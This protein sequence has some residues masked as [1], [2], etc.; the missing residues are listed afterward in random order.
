M[1]GDCESAFLEGGWTGELTTADDSI[2]YDKFFPNRLN[3]FNFLNDLLNRFRMQPESDKIPSQGKANIKTVAAAAGVS[4]ATVSNAFNR[5][6]QLSAEVRERVLNVAR[7]IGYGGANPVA[8]N[9]RR[10]STN[11]VGFVY[12]ESLEFGLNDPASQQFLQGIAR[13]L[14]S[15]GL[16]L[17]LLPYSATANSETVRNAAVDGIIL[18][19][20]PINT[21]L[22]QVVKDRRLPAVFVDYPN[23]S[24]CTTVRVRDRS[25][26]HALAEHLIQLGH[27]RFG[28][29][30]GRLTEDFR[31]GFSDWSR[32]QHAFYYPE[33]ERLTGYRQALEEANIDLSRQVRI[34]ECKHSATSFGKRA[35]AAFLAA[36]FKPTAVLA[37]SDMLAI[38]AIEQLKASGFKV[39]A[40]VSVA[41]FD[42]VPEAS[43]IEPTL[44]TVRQDS[45]EKGRRAAKFLL[46]MLDGQGEESRHTVLQTQLIVRKSTGKAR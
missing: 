20:P 28:I 37:F 23:R 24:D 11:T 30:S 43:R 1:V 12:S 19:C 2:H 33:K 7:E 27:K 22:V 14:E 46:E 21:P 15:R 6:N 26:A 8:R 39:P 16:A 9:L 29:I 45:E 36:E 31:E 42:D 25:G 34:F 3:I 18:Y 5:P 13:A 32:L 41:G 35:I 17:L 40:D 4:T 44:T 10:M 38:G